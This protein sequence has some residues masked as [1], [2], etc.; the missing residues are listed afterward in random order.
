MESANQ[1]YPYYTF[2]EYVALE[3]TAGARYMYFDGQ[4]V[5]M[6][7]STKRHNLIVQNLTVALRGHARRNGCQVYAENVRQKLHTG[8]RYVYPDIIYT[9]N[10]ADLADDAE[11]FVR[12]PSMIIEVLS[13]STAQDDHQDKRFD[14][15]KIPSLLCYI[16]V[17]QTTCRVEIYE[18]TNDFWKYR[19]FDQLQDTVDISSLGIT[20]SIND[21]YEDISF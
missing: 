16:L 13:E 19:V 8:E 14:Y 15:Y 4:V 3:A 2:A 11:S 18:R 6:A 9:C 10:P 5:A 17:S 1:S 21:I 7:G 12:W 20:L